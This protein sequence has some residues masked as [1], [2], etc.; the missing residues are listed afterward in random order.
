MF[1][2]SVHARYSSSACVRRCV[3]STLSIAWFCLSMGACVSMRACVRACVHACMRFAVCFCMSVGICICAV[4][5]HV[6]VYAQE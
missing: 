5:R 1:G 3:C 6:Y 4:C 2:N